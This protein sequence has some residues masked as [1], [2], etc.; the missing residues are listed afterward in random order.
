MSH[1]YLA[2]LWAHFYDDT[3]KINQGLFFGGQRRFYFFVFI[4][5]ALDEK[6]KRKKDQILFTKMIKE[7]QFF[8]CND[9]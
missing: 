4:S 5:L 2:L 9:D 1:I 7:L 6:E 3:V 8:T